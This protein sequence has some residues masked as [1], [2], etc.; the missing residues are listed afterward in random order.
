MDVGAVLP[1]AHEPEELI[2]KILDN[3]YRLLDQLG[4]GGMGTVYRAEHVVLGEQ[5]AIKLLSPRFAYDREWVQRFLTEARAARRI[6]HPHIVR[7]VDVAVAGPGLVYMV[8]ELLAGETLS[9]LVRREGPL[10]WQRTFHIIR[11]V[12]SALAAAHASGVVHRD[13][14]PANCIVAT[15]AAGGDHVKVL[16]FGIAKLTEARDRD[17]APQTVTGMW[18]GTSEYMAPEMFRGEPAGAS[19][20]I[21]AVGVLTYKLLTGVTPFRGNHIEVATQLQQRDAAPP[22]TLA[23]QPAE[24][25]AVVLRALARDAAARTP[26]M[27]AL[28]DDMTAVLALPPAPVPEV[29]VPVPMPVAE[30]PEGDTSVVV[31]HHHED[32][33]STERA[34]VSTFVTRHLSLL[35]AGS[36]VLG[37]VL[38]VMLILSFGSRGEAPTEVAAA[39]EPPVAAEPQPKVEP[40]KVEPP[41]VEP[42][43]EA[44][45][46]APD[47]PPQEVGAGPTDTAGPTRTK[48]GV[49]AKKKTAKKK[50]EGLPEILTV[51][52][53]RAELQS[54][55]R[56]VQE[57]CFRANRAVAGT[58]VQMDV[59]VDANGK[60]TAKLATPKY[61][62]FGAC[63][64]YWIRGHFFPRSRSG[65]Q[66]QH[67]FVAE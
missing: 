45:P 37:L 7:I 65:G 21:Y 58:R 34:L 13:I 55:R 60:A 28:V 33:P 47:T 3:R 2:G 25:D 26:S 30:E 56:V 52:V 9:S 15:D 36:V 35:L 66:I 19:M 39:V 42:K 53:L 20:D 18:M 61:T 1:G 12:A 59:S 46:P 5:V 17:S 4:E 67:V 10:P 41:R 14:K 22:S 48:S 24:V 8:M 40:P 54:I 51:P 38:V 31:S 57:K 6:Q 43:V 64:D 62:Q 23:P 44:T 50:T 63:L 29:P 49:V 32:A 11:Q 16:D 27:T